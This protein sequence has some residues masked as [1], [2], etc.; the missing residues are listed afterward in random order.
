[1]P[2][3][4]NAFRALGLSCHASQTEIY[5][6]ASSIRRAIKLGV[7]RPQQQH[8]F[9][10]LGSPDRTENGV[11][12]ALS[13]LADP[14]QRIYERLFWFFAPQEITA[15]AE[16]SFSTLEESIERLRRLAEPSAG[17]D[18]ALLSLVSMLELDPRLL[19][20]DGWRRTYALWK[21]LI[22]AREFWSLL[23]ASD[24]KGDFEQVTTF[25]E[26]KIL[27]ARAWR[28][29]T[30]PVAEIA[31]D[32]VLRDDEELARRALDTLRLPVLPPALAYEYENE[33]LAPVE[34]RFDALFA[35]AF[36]DYRYEVKLDQTLGERRATCERALEKFYAQVKPALTNILKLAG[37]ESLVTR[38]V[39]QTAAE[40]LDELADGFL[41][42]F[43]TAARL[44]TLRR[45]WLLAPPESS[46]LLLIEEH[47]KEAG[48]LQERPAKTDADFARHI[49]LALREPAAQPELFTSYMQKEES[50]KKFEGCGAVVGKI[51]L[52]LMLTIFVGK[53][54]SNLPG[55]RRSRLPP[56][57][58]FNVAMPRFT[59]PKMPELNLSKLVLR[60]SARHLEAK[61][62]LKSAVVVDVGTKNEYDAGHI[63]GAIL[64]PASQLAARAARLPKS[65][66]IVLY[67][68]CSGQELSMRAAVELQS[69]GFENVS[70]LEGG[71]QAWLDAGLPV[72]QGK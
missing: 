1:M 61:L 46:S 9:D 59:P 60:I 72:K 62:I 2:V 12:D 39:F 68:K 31:K 8:Q 40:G 64:I 44:K 69:K 58:N 67:C 6:A 27:R 43:D 22:D 54:F 28:L 32:A 45:A 56:P 51:A 10:W 3:A 24:L 29:V 23:M 11:R 35:E 52:F 21:E 70:V 41:S 33:I 13:R 65:K 71:Y 63:P 47:L 16:L 34:D 4:G 38:R 53:C 55:S 42:A 14:A 26:I 49:S 50:A 66:E 25:G 18:I 30:S 37:L 36:R 15:A 20:A 17:H 7:E 48:D 57:I 5:A 19:N